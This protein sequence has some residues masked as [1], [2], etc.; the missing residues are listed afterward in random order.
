MTICMAQEPESLFLY[1]DISVAARSVREAIYDGPI[2]ILGYEPAPVILEEFPSLENGGVSIETV[3]VQ[4]G[5]YLIDAD[6]NLATLAEG[7]TFFPAGCSDRA[8][9]QEYTDQTEITM[10]QVVLHFGLVAGI[11]WADG[12]PLT[13]DD[14]LYSF[15]VA[16]A[17][18]PRVRA[19]TLMRT[20]AYQVVDDGT[21]EWR[22]VPGY[23]PA[24]YIPLFFT[25]LP[26]HAWGQL[27]VEELFS[28]EISSRRPMGWGPYM[29][30]E[31]V[32]GDHISLS[33][34]RNY[35]K[36]SQDL[37]HFDHLVFRFV[38]SR[39]EALAALLSGECDYVDETAGLEQGSH[40]L[41]ELQ[42]AGR[43]AVFMETGTA[44]EHADFGLVP[45]T[46]P[47]SMETPVVVGEAQTSLFAQKETRQAIVQ[48]IDRQRMA[49]E[50]FLGS[51]QVLDTYVPMDHPLYNPEAA[52]YEF[53][54]QAGAALLDSIGWIDEDGD[55]ATPR[56]AAGVPG[57]AN[58]TPFEFTFLTTAEDEK[59]RAGEIL[60]QSLGECGISVQ[61]KALS[62][63]ELTAPG[64]DGVVFGRHFSLAQFAWITSLEPPCFLYTTGEIPGPYPQFP[65]GWGGANVSGFSNS[66][67][68]QACAQAM[69]TLPD[70]SEHRQSHLQAQAIFAEELPV[71]PLYSR[72]KLVA[73]RADICGVIVDPSADSAL[74][75]VEAFDYGENCSTGN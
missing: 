22:G 60:R 42:D 8:C 6:G 70:T 53:N 51:S 21:I 13:A 20:R 67:F 69:A 54:P 35:F 36:A 5:D 65:K 14:S 26:R 49:D 19:D 50:L 4:T 10:D 12:S 2:D 41:L 17:I 48:C 24:N 15:E 64:P 75:N 73:T 57:I 16:Q 27:P 66:E 30:D 56:V 55:V 7:V 46:P 33:K 74:W 1:G 71:I 62:W 11:Q 3:Q 45:Y 28:A 63:E 59:L 34:N 52:H 31:W 18:Y 9:A 61:V 39:D 40:N 32:A 23:R 29:I 58:G 25:P 47:D 37:P 38:G 72:L 44:W 68:D 43:I